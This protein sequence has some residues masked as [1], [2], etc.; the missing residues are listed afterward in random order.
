MDNNDLTEKETLTQVVKFLS[1]VL[2]HGTHDEI[3]AVNIHVSSNVMK[4]D[5]IMMKY[6]N[7]IVEED[8]KSQIIK[9]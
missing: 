5:K 7:R 4:V 3:R 1:Y 6:W 2:E 9:G 8:Q